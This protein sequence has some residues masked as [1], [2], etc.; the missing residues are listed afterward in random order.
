MY[1]TS[2]GGP[3]GCV[4][5]DGI[6]R[7]PVLSTQHCPQAVSTKPSVE[8]SWTRCVVCSGVRGSHLHRCNLHLRRSRC[9]CE[10]TSCSCG[11]DNI[12][13]SENFSVSLQ[14]PSAVELFNNSLQHVFPP[15]R[16]FDTH[17]HT[18]THAYTST[19]HFALM[20]A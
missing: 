18:H 17:T 9:Y 6:T 12:P 10:H 20:M 11:L 2:V 8:G 4:L 5:S 15:F 7:R 13:Q 19:G 16:H 1:E 3:A 14:C